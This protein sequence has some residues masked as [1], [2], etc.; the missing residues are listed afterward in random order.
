M[1]KVVLIII[2]LAIIGIT[3]AGYYFIAQFSS[4]PTTTP[5]SPTI[6]SSPTQTTFCSKDQLTATIAAQGAAGNIYA[7]LTMTNTGKTTCTI[8]LGN[9]VTA[10]FAAQNITVHYLEDSTPNRLL[11]AP[12]A[13]V[14][15]QVHYPNGPQ[16]QS[17]IKEQPVTFLYKADQETVAFVPNAQT[18][19][20]AL[21]A[22]S[23]PQEKTQ[24]DIW[25]L[26]KQPV[27]P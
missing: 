24:I 12:S 3:V 13:S 2:L 17:G 21:Q 20:V 25:P 4:A 26:S 18:G 19:K 10:L 22:C 8:I 27:T 23:S 14:Y 7:T 5:Q 6:T 15:S 16:C 9:T 11:L 1:K